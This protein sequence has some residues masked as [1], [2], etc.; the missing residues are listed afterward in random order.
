MPSTPANDAPASIREQAIAFAKVHLQQLVGDLIHWRRKGVL[1][2][3]SLM[4]RL[5]GILEPD[6]AS[7]DS[8]QRAEYIV[9]S[10]ALQ[11]VAEGPAES[12][13]RR[14]EGASQSLRGIADRGRAQLGDAY[15]EVLQVLGTVRTCLEVLGDDDQAKANTPRMQSVNLRLPVTPRRARD[16]MEVRIKGTYHALS[17]SALSVLAAGARRARAAAPLGAV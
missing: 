7:D 12:V 3:G 14:L 4:T 11:Q 5:S 6:C 8:M 2:A 16:V 15:P 13:K 1:P 9:S 10:L 17:A